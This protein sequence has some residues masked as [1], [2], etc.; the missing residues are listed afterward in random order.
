LPER[1]FQDLVD[2]NLQ[3]QR[4]SDYADY[5]AVRAYCALS[6]D[7]V[8][9]LVLALFDATT[10]RTVALSDDVCTALQLLEF[11]QDVAEDRRDGR[12]Y[13]PQ[14]TLALF[15]VD[16]GDLDSAA[17]SPALRRALAYETD[18]AEALLKSGD[19]LVGLLHGWGRIAVAGYVAGG[20]A[21]VSALRRERFDVLAVTPRPSKRDTL[22]HALRLLAGGRR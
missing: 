18:R 1:P 5:A 11:W 21:T 8:G 22:G 15:G 3:D 12:V 6:A 20:R 17:T 13:L 7:P 16:A 14:D 9:R 4:V 19:E 10:P 2:A